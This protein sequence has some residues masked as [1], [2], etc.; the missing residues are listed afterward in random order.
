M[1]IVAEVK[2]LEELLSGVRSQW[3]PRELNSSLSS[4][5]LLQSYE[6]IRCY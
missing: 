2:R 3:L 6:T 4:S 1:L 5:T